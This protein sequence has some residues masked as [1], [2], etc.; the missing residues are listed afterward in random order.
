MD[1]HYH[2][3]SIDINMPLHKWHWLCQHIIASTNEVHVEHIVISYNAEDSLIVIS[4]R[5]GIKLYDN[6]CLRMRLDNALSLGEGKNVSLVREEMERGWLITL[7][8][9]VEETICYALQLNFTE[10]NALTRKAYV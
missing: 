9:Y 8:D 2:F 10:V 6:S 1:T 7:V 3:V 5:L 4:G